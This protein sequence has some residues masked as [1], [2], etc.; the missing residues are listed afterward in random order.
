MFGEEK[1]QLPQ[2]SM[3]CI[4]VISYLSPNLSYFFPFFMYPHIKNGFE[5]KRDKHLKQKYFGA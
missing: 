3:D 2:F 4:G 5:I 1:N